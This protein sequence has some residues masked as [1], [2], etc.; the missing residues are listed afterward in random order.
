MQLTR[1]LLSVS[2][3]LAPVVSGN[4][5]PESDGLTSVE[6]LFARASYDCPATNNG[7]GRNYEAHSYTSGQ[8][9]AAK[10]AAQKIMQT[11]GEKWRPGAQDYPHFF[12]NN[13]KFPFNCGKNKAEYP[14]NT[15][16]KTWQPGQAV[17]TLPDRVIFEFSWKKGKV[18]TKECG[19]IRHGPP[20]AND[21]LQCA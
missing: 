8:I 1:I 9:T 19:V 12:N 18:S 20:P 6:N 14:L 13:E 2:V 5:I 17:Q 21:F 10:A 7:Q 16:G 4:P 15:D 11:K 3:L